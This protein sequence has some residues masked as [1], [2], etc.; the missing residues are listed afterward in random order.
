MALL[1]KQSGIFSDLD[2]IYFN[3]DFAK[4]K[5]KIA[6]QNIDLKHPHYWNNNFLDFDK[7]H[8]FIRLLIDN[9][10]KSYK[11]FHPWGSVGPGLV[12]DTLR[13]CYFDKNEEIRNSC[14]SVERLDIKYFQS[15]HSSGVWK[16][17]N[18]LPTRLE[19]LT[20][21]LTR[22]LIHKDIDASFFRSYGYH[23]GNTAIGPSHIP[24]GSL[25]YTLMMNYCPK[26]SIKFFDDIFK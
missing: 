10:V 20:N 25:L 14:R 2:I 1:T 7:N 3:P 21:L 16:A 26:I 24:V 17:E 15:V 18:P 19:D 22:Y 8:P 4:T 9:Y 12:T 11:P 5:N 13:E 6:S 23:F